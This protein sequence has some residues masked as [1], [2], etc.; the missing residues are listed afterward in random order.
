MNFFFLANLHGFQLQCFVIELLKKTTKFMSLSKAKRRWNDHKSV[1]SVFNDNTVHMP[2]RNFNFYFHQA[3]IIRLPFF[4]W[5]LF[6]LSLQTN[7]CVFL[8]FQLNCKTGSMIW[9]IFNRNSNECSWCVNLI[10][11]KIQTVDSQQKKIHQQK[12]R[13]FHRH[14]AFI[15]IL[16]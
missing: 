2:R 6:F 14:F 10:H 15:F 16:K 13:V 3:E 11:I 12:F 5:L 9:L 1:S 7:K 4:S 8:K